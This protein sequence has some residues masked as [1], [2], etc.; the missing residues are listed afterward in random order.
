MWPFWVSQP[1]RL[2]GNQTPAWESHHGGNY[3]RGDQCGRF[4][5][6]VGSPLF[7]WQWDTT[8]KV[9]A[10]NPDGLWTHSDVCLVIPRQ[11]GKTQIVVARILYGLFFLGE[12]IT[13]TAQRWETVEDVYDRIVDII[14][15]RPSLARR[16]DPSEVPEGHTKAGNHGRIALTN[17][18]SLSMGPRTKAKGRGQTKIDLAIFDEAYDIKEVLVSG[19]TGA[20]KASDNPQTI[21]VSTAPVADQHPDCGTLAVMWRNGKRREPDLYAAEWR[22]PDGLPRDEPETWRIAQPSHGVTVR[23]RDVASEL[24]R[25]KT[26]TLLAIFDADYLGWGVWPVDPDDVAMP[27]DVDA[28]EGLIDLAPLLVG[29]I[30]LAVERT[31]DRA[32]WCIAAG[33]RTIDGGVHLEVGYWHAVNIGQVAVALV[34][35]IEACD[36]KAIVIDAKSKASPLVPYMLNKGVEI[37]VTNTPQLANATLGL[38][39]AVP[40]GDISHTGQ[41]ILSRAVESAITRELPRGDVVWDDVESGSA[42]APLKAITLAHWG[43]LEFAEEPGPAASPDLGTDYGPQDLDDMSVLEARF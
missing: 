39:D 36:P 42:L 33:Q 16:L 43:V 1:E 19:I 8:R 40:A 18:A 32:W 28:W 15:R 29:D 12:K 10:T 37:T 24:R 11:Q 4:M 21:F 9:L 2:T 27:I 23:A 14:D 25:S 31:L 30:V 7:G 5:H 34:E 17:G 35:L 20:Q 3:D 13:Y 6:K 26:A 38:I 41:P 22:A